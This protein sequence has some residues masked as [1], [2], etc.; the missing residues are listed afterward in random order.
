MRLDKADNKSIWAAPTSDQTYTSNTTLADVAG[1]VLSLQA[2][3][4][5]EIEG[6]IIHDGDAA[7]DIKLKC[8]IPAGAVLDVEYI[9][10]NAAAAS[11]VA[12]VNVADTGTSSQ[13]EGEVGAGTLMAILIKGKIV[14]GSTPGNLQLQAAQA[15][16]SAVTT[17]LHAQGSYIR[18]VPIR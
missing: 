15:A 18:A 1:C 3:Q 8:N 7:A 9:A 2:N 11:T 13:T 5:Y 10:P 17:T 16:S 12:A 6:Q 14:M 4:S